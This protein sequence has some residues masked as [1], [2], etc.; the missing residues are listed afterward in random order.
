M[1]ISFKFKSKSI[2]SNNKFIKYTILN[3][4]MFINALNQEIFKNRLN[5][6]YEDDSHNQNKSNYF[7]KIQM[8]C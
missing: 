8:N 5:E 4:N 1:T 7:K 2:W 6:S 3:Q